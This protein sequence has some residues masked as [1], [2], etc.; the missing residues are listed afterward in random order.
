MLDIPGPPPP[1]EESVE[2]YAMAYWRN[3]TSATG[4]DQSGSEDHIDEY[5]AHL[6]DRNTGEVR[7]NA[8]GGRAHDCL[9]YGL[10]CALPTHSDR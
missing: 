4:P 7:F 8:L 5:A 2:L 3:C 6:E 1:S 9:E 10:R